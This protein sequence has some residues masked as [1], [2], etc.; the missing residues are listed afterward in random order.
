MMK[1][2]QALL[3]KAPKKKGKGRTKREDPMFVLNVELQ[4]WGPLI[5]PP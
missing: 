5:S 1:P 2:W 4:K 3:K